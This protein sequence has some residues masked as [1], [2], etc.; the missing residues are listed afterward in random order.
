MRKRYSTGQPNL[1]N[2]AKVDV[3]ARAST[4]GDDFYWEDVPIYTYM[5]VHEEEKYRQ[6]FI[7]IVDIDGDPIWCEEMVDPYGFD[8]RTEEEKEEQEYG[9]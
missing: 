5:T 2:I 4:R 7:G 6:R 9:I 8:L 3:S 1:K